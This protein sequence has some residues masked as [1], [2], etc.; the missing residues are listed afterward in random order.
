ML[1]YLYNH[2]NKFLI[3]NSLKYRKAY[4]FLFT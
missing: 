1:F 4:N 3:Y 2:K